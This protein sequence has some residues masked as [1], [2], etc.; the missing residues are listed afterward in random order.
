MNLYLAMKTHNNEAV[1]MDKAGKI[2]GMF[3]ATSTNDCERLRTMLL[4]MS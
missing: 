3:D 4:E 2:R 1:V